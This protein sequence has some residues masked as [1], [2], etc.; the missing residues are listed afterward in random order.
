MGDGLGQIILALLIDIGGCRRA[1]EPL[2][3]V[4]PYAVH[5]AVLLL[6]AAVELDHAV[7]RVGDSVILSL[8]AVGQHIGELAVGEQEV[9]HFHGLLGI[10]RI[11]G[12]E[13]QHARIH[14]RSHPGRAQVDLHNLRSG[15]QLGILPGSGG[16]HADVG[17]SLGRREQVVPG[18]V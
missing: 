14:I 17:G 13:E 6:R 15:L 7:L 2:G 16:A 5:V 3:P 4:A 11:G 10:G 18:L 1:D 8:H 9:Q 12:D